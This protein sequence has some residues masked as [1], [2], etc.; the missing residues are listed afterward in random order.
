MYALVTGTT[1]FESEYRKG[2][3]KNILEASV[4]FGE[5]FDGFSA[6]FKVLIRKTLQKDPQKRLTMNEV[7]CNP[8]F[9]SSSIP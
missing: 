3:I 4:Q 7:F 8:W 9:F 2:T 1:P 5:E 6:E